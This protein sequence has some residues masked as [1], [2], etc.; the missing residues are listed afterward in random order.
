MSLTSLIAKLPQGFEIVLADIGSAGGLH[1]RWQ[2]A[3]PVV[4]GVLFEPREGGQV[5]RE[6][7][8]TI[9]PI[10]LGEAEGMARLNLTALVNMSSTLRPNASLL[11][12]FAKKGKHTEITGTIDM[13]VDTLDAIAVRD[14]LRIDAI[15]VDTQGSELG[16]LKGARR[17]LHASVV[18][19]EVEV[20]F[21]HRYEGQALLG[22]IVSFMADQ[23]FELI[24]LYRLKRYRRANAAGVGNTSLGGGQRAGRLAYGDAIFF[25]REDA[26]AA[27][28]AAASEAEAEAIALRAIVAMTIYGKPDM[29]AHWLD[30]F[31]AAIREPSRA[32]LAAWF[33]RLAGR[34]LRTG[35]LHHAFDWLARRV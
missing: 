34:P 4:S 28:I 24:D 16:I 23:G 9:Y 14:A 26:L 25:L 2:A 1:G 31:G 7:R 11:Q 10:G 17:C 29:A 13:Q 18:M 3:R 32:A 12:S 6:G 15:K 30:T 5:R 19:A 27:R 35:V 33:N 20:S 21:F 8:D 22:D